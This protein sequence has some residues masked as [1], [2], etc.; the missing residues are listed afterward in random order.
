MN[1]YDWTTTEDEIRE[2]IIYET[3]FL[4]ILRLLNRQWKHHQ[5]DTYSPLKH[6]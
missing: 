6:L 1:F 4:E 3:D 5:F 2:Q